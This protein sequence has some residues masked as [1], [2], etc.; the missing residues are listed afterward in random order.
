MNR[1]PHPYIQNKTGWCWAVC[2]EIVACHYTLSHPAHGFDIEVWRREY[3]YGIKTSDLQGIR[4]QYAGLLEDEIT[5][6]A[7][8]WA[9]VKSAN[10]GN[11]GMAWDLGKENALRYAVTGDMRTG[12]ISVFTIGSQNES[13]K[14]RQNALMEYWCSGNRF[15]F[16]IGN[17][18]IAGLDKA[19]SVALRGNENKVLLYDPWSGYNYQCKPEDIFVRGISSR[20]GQVM[21][22][23]MQIIN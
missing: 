1:I 18:Y 11:M 8:Q 20:L 3:P 6:D 13:N 2:A 16:A 15:R 21:I 17:F 7:V 12:K 14:A 9:I 5:V 10:D 19:H 4:L 23:W 22:S